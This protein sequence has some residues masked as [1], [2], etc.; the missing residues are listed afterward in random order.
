M[1]P[2]MAGV[3]RREIDELTERA[4]RFGARAWRIS[5]SSRTATVKGPIAKFLA[6][7]T[8]RGDR[9]ADRREPKATS[10]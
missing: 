5:R 9:R 10:S 7:D 3:T 4:R 8:Q 2:G 1:A 6:D